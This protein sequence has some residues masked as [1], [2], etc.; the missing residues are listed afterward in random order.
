M[1]TGDYMINIKT[2]SRKVK[3]GDIFAAVKCEVNDGHKYIDAAIK[4]G[5]SKII[6]EN[7]NYDVETIV[8]D[9]SRKYLTD[10]LKDNYNKYL[11][12]MNIIGITGTNGKTTTAYL[13]YDMLNKM[14]DKCAYIGTIGYY[15][16]KKIC[17]LPNTNPDICEMYDMIINAYD[18]GY[19]NVVIEA[20][21]QGLHFGRL[22]NI[23][24]NYA[25]FT[26]LTQ[27]HLDY[28]V[29][30]ENYALAKQLLFKKLKKDGLSILNYDSEYSKY[31]VTDNTLYYGFNGGDYHITDYKMGSNTK[32]TYTYKDKE[33]EIT[34][35]LIGDYNINNLLLA[36][37]VV[38]Q[39]GKNINDIIN[40]IPKLTC[41]P[42]RMDIIRYNKSTIIVDYAHTPDAVEKIINTVKNVS[43][44]KIYVVFGC[45]GDRDRTKRPIMT[46]IVL[47]NSHMGIITIDDLHDEDPDR[48]VSDMLSENKRNNYR[49]YLDRKEAIEYGINKL[50]DNDFLLILGKGHEE[51]II[52]K[53][54]RIPFNDHNVVMDIIKEKVEMI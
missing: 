19:K 32:F 8:V 9:D 31:F 34:S 45:T 5:A 44:G 2:D 38:E 29:T 30:M 28:H 20:S 6:C 53:D 54:K 27:D 23:E 43:C 7:G 50:E 26:N 1:I 33:Y 40:I 22:E 47:S 14:G 16:D 41:P 12:E 18:N 51:A 25:C 35:P 37:I 10:Y 49:I 11:D 17:D 15:L 36:L 4:N 42:G 24:F 39:M 52:V 48:I 46:E 13:I 3:K 21:S